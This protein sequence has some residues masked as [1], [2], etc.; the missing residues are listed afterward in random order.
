MCNEN[1]EI[2]QI[3]WIIIKPTSFNL[4]ASWMNDA[5][6]GRIWDYFVEES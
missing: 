3:E 4:A 2:I 5:V 6:R 1:S